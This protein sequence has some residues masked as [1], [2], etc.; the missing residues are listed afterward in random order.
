MKKV[1]L[2]IL[3]GS[4]LLALIPT[5]A[6]ADADDYYY[7]RWRHQEWRERQRRLHE[8][9]EREWREHWWREHHTYYDRD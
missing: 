7:W 2:S 8:W 1:L 5:Q 6:R 9:R 3:L 4:G